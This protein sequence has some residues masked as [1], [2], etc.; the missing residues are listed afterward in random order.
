MFHEFGHGL[1]GL[2]SRVQYP[3]MSGTSTPRDFVE[4]PSQFNEH[5]ALE[6]SVFANYARHYQTGAP[7]PAELV[8]KIK[9]AAKFNQ[10][11]GTLEALESA[12]VDLAS[13]TRS[14]Q[15]RRCRRSPRSS[16]LAALKEARGPSC[17][18]SRRAIT[19]RTSSTSGT[20]ATRP[21]TPTRG[22]RCSPDVRV[23]HRA[24][25]AHR[26][27][28]GKKFR[29]AILSR[30][31]TVDAHKLYVDF[32]AAS[33]RRDALLEHRAPQTSGS[34]LPLPLH[35]FWGKDRLCRGSHV[36]SSTRFP[37]RNRE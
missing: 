6:A 12:L 9:K 32:A 27:E 11:F 8:A 20:A 36:R 30:G 37:P 28:R 22:P 7:M 3:Y 21:A 16:S 15:R 25:R 14:T 4:F 1:H 29:D 35:Y 17:G 5:W 2:F 23:V 31:G 26:G 33:P 24:R 34:R 18:R 19:R 10:G 13:G